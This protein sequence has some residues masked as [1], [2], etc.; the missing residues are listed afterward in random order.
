MISR[1]YAER[2]LKQTEYELRF[3]SPNRRAYESGVHMPVYFA[4]GPR[5]WYPV[6]DNGIA[7]L[8]IAPW[9]DMEYPD[10]IGRGIG[11]TGE[12]ELFRR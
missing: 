11:F 7:E 2:I 1:E 5:K 12:V 4:V 6:G 10:L 8:Y 9:H 3:V